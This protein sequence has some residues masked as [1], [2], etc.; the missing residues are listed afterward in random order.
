[1]VEWKKYGDTGYM[2]NSSGEVL[3]V[4]R[5]RK[6]KP[7]PNSKGYLRVRINKKDVFVH[8]L[9]GLLF[10]NNKRISEAV[11]INHKNFDI[12]DNRASNLEWVTPSENKLHNRKKWHI[13]KGYK[14]KKPDDCPF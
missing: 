14:Y 10:I 6:L 8:R 9:V 11:Q 13:P 1:M 5:N 2:V 7:Y 3:N 12:R 4:K